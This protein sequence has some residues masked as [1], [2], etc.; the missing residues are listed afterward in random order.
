MLT[1]FVQRLFSSLSCWVTVQP[2]LSVSLAD[3]VFMWPWSVRGHLLAIGFWS[4]SFCSALETSGI[5][6]VAK[7]DISLDVVPFNVLVSQA[8]SKVSIFV[9]GFQ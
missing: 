7:S 2:L 5:V 4:R 8:A 9:F 6:S 1:V 3:V